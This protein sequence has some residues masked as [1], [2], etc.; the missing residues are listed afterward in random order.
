MHLLTE[1]QKYIYSTYMLT[2]GLSAT[3]F[4]FNHAPQGTDYPIVTY[5]VVS[6]VPTMAM[7]S[8]GNDYAQ[9]RIQFQVFVNEQQYSQG[10]SILQ[11]LEDTFHRKTNVTLNNDVTLICSKIQG[12][13]IS[14]FNSEE[15]IWQ[16]SEDYS[17]MVGK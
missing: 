2:A 14:F 15:K 8:T 16:I 9:Y 11:S 12:N 3:P 13:V 1:T 5:N 4:Y 7:G 6:N 10:M 17:F